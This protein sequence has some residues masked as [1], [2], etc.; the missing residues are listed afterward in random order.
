MA[1]RLDDVCL[2]VLMLDGIELKGRTNVVALGITSDGVKIPLGLLR[3]IDRERHRGDSPA[4]R[5]GR[6]RARHDP[7]G[8]LRARRLQG[9]PQGGARRAQRASTGRALASA[10]RSATSSITCLKRD[11]AGVRWRLR[12]AWADPDHARALDRLEQLADELERSHPGAAASL[13]E[14]MAETL[15]LTRLGISGP[16]TRTLAAT[17]PIESM[18]ACVRPTARNV[19]RW[20]S[21]EMA[22]RWS[23]AGMLRGRAPVPADHRLPAARHAGPNDRARSRPAHDERG[24]GYPRH[25]IVTARDRRRSSTTS[26][27]SSHRPD[28]PRDRPPRPRRQPSC[29][30]LACARWRLC[31]HVRLLRAPRENTTAGAERRIDQ[32]AQ[33]GGAWSLISRT[34]CVIRRDR[35]RRILPGSRG[36]AWVVGRAPP[37]VPS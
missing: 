13:R 24:G 37:N 18:I 23:A 33:S 28:D 3:G 26:G 15:T 30:S 2:A 36:T 11:R 12:G 9:A 35:L 20:Q 8:A 10:T 1:R 4:G 21:G 16:L 34:M 14:G 32:H 25:C 7:R 27:T 17:N 29:R 6:A 5:P 22:L 19:K 31:R